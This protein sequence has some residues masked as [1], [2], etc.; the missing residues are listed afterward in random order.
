MRLNLLKKVKEQL[1]DKVV[2][3]QGDDEYY[4]S[5]CKLEFYIGKL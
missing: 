1:V 5:K 2:K 3:I 4:A